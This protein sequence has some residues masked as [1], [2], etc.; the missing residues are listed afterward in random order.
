MF[1]FLIQVS[2]LILTAELKDL[3][4]LRE[5][6]QKAGKALPERPYGLKS[7]PGTACEK[8]QELVKNWAMMLITVEM[9]S[10][11]PTLSLLIIYRAMWRCLCFCL[12]N[13]WKSLITSHLGYNKF[14]NSSSHKICSD[15]LLM[16]LAKLL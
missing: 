15:I 6:P 14:C 13:P 16:T 9:S 10:W 1:L 2:Y 7:P 12:S 3:F 11:N 4:Q 8:S 5:L